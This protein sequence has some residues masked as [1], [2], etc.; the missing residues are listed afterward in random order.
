VVKLALGAESW[1]SITEH[2][3]EA[4][5]HVRWGLWRQTTDR[6]CGCSV[7]LVRKEW[8]GVDTVLLYGC[9]WDGGGYT[10]AAITCPLAL[11]FTRR[12]LRRSCAG[13]AKQGHGLGFRL[14]AVAMVNM[15]AG[16]GT[17]DGR[18]EGMNQ[19]V[20]S[21]DSTACVGGTKV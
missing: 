18:R 17:R 21:V 5:P 20:G 12:V 11:G 16:R 2:L 4:L 10:R 1:L 6:V 15:I 14:G 3:I 8:V 19:H 13:A 9:G 7:G